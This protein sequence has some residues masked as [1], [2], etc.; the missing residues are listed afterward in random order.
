MVV[1]PV[2]TFTVRRLKNA[3]P[4]FTPR[5]CTVSTPVGVVR[6]KMS[7][8]PTILGRFFSSDTRR[9]VS[10]TDAVS[11]VPVRPPTMCDRSCTSAQPDKYAHASRVRSGAN[12]G[13]TRAFLTSLLAR[14]K[15]KNSAPARNET[16][17][18]GRWF[19]P[20]KELAKE[21]RNRDTPMMTNFFAA[22]IAIHSPL[23]NPNFA[24]AAAAVPAT[25][26][27]TPYS[28]TLSDLG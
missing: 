5:Y 23:N 15:Q 18:L 21:C 20:L 3:F 12:R 6:P 16:P 11:G 1:A 10:P 17:E 9:T 2:S 19:L 14:Y 22:R 7:A 25:S 4:S 8:F 13:F 26:A 24:A 27:A 28:A